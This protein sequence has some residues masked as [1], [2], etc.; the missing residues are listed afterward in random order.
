MVL[1][2]PSPGFAMDL[3]YRQVSEELSEIMRNSQRSQRSDPVPRNSGVAMGVPPARW[4]VS[5]G[6]T[7]HEKK[8]FFDHMIHHSI[9]ILTII[10]P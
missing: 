10:F 8:R 2:W 9:P 5:K 6:G 4:M 1:P 7:S 3:F